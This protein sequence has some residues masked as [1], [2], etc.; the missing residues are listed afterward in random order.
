MSSENQAKQ[1]GGA[2]TC[3][4]IEIIRKYLQ[5]RIMPPVETMYD[6]DFACDNSSLG[7][8]GRLKSASRRLY[9]SGDKLIHVTG[10]AVIP[11]EEFITEITKVHEGDVGEAHLNFQETLDKVILSLRSCEN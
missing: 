11:M 3:S 4:Q 5:T 8:H 9:L 7:V 10:K 6:A 1:R 2:F